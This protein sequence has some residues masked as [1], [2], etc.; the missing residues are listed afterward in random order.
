[1]RISITYSVDED[2]VDQ[3]ARITGLETSVDR[4][5]KG[6][7]LIGFSDFKIGPQTVLVQTLS[8]GVDHF[9]FHEVNDS[10]TICS[11]AGAYSNVVTEMVF[12]QLLS[13]IKKICKFS[14]DMKNGKFS[15]EPT[16]RLEDL[17]LGILGFGGIGRQVAKIAKAFDM[18][19]IAFSRTLNSTEN[20]DF[21]AE[22]PQALF[23]D[24]DVVV[25]AAPL[26]MATKGMV[27]E[28]MLS[29]F[30]GSYIV[31]IARA[32]VVD[33]EAML[34]FLKE[35][36]DKYYLS[37]VWWGEPEMTVPVPENAVLTPHVG[38]FTKNTLRDVTVKACENVRRFLDGHPENVVDRG[39]YGKQ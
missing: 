1:M 25:I 11:N 28:K 4:D 13:H 33:K 34:G 17:T 21:R 24:S 7:V 18:K 5:C 3:C 10:V 8:A 31:N 39:D 36:P 14:T 26:N 9:D 12:A 23:T 32:E 35:N 15:R 38:G 27:D 37:D 16:V 22:S 29:V 2:I 19:T 30:R 6:E 20:L